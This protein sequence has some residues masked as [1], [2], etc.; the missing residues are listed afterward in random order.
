MATQTQIAEKLGISDRWLRKLVESGAVTDPGRNQWD[1]LSVARQ[2]L[3]YEKAETARLKAEIARLNAELQ[4]NEGSGAIKTDEEARRMR[5]LADKAEMEVAEMR[6]QLVPADQIAEAMHGAVVIMK[7]RLSG[8]PAKV[9]PIAHAAPSIA[10]AEKLI[11]DQIDETL[12]D[13][14]KVEIVATVASA[15]AA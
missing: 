11:R 14:G 7:T 2:L 5:A 3:A 6:G 13:L 10:A 1:A 8:I 9:A 15:P 4:R 12:A